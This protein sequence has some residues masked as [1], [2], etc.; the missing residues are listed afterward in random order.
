MGS[1][2]FTI[3]MEKHCI[4]VR[5]MIFRNDYYYIPLQFKIFRSSFMFFASTPSLIIS[6]VLAV[7]YLANLA[8]I[9]INRQQDAGNA[10][11]IVAI[12]HENERLLQ[13][14][15]LIYG[16]DN[17]LKHKVRSDSR[18]GDIHVWDFFGAFIDR[19]TFLQS[20]PDL[21]SPISEPGMI[22]NLFSRPPPIC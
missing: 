3:H 15:V 7:F 14:A 2:R 13:H 18:K 21:S 17:T 1:I 19:D 4:S 16:E 10:V 20:L 6:L 11:E 8:L 12:S 9:A 22:W 5:D